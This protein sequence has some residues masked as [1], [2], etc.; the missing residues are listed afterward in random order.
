VTHGIAHN[1]ARTG[2]KASTRV[3]LSLRQRRV[4][5]LDWARHDIYDKVIG[6]FIVISK[7][8]S[9]PVIIP[10]NVHNM[11]ECYEPEPKGY[12]PELFS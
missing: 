5:P 12:D 8:L 2:H 7:E 6:Q 3:T 11:D 1:R 9:N 10:E 4:R